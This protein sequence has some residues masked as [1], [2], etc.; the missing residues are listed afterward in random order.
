MKI[1][2]KK[3]PTHIAIIMDGNGRWAKKRNLPKIAGHGQGVKTV[4]KIIAAAKK[5][6]VRVL[7]LYAFSTE[8]WKRPKKE[9][10]GLMSLLENYLEKQALKLHKEGVRLS[11]IGD[12]EGLP[13][14]VSKK[15]KE[16]IELTKSNTSFTL[17]IALNYG[18]RMEIVE[19]TKSILKDI[20]R[21]ALSIENL[22]E[23][24]FSRYLYTNNIPDP[25]LLIRTS[26]EMRV[27]N[28]LLWQIAYTEFYI[29]EKF[30][31]D[32]TEKDFEKAIA[33]FQKRKRR[34]GGR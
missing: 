7:S 6:G 18:A 12:I 5:R 15:L 16:V 28:F 30:W 13:A 11:A 4:E 24:V 10:D 19:A 25:D 1:D 26:G 21:G 29:T 9:V 32:F 17:N 3:I 34:F 22:T 33:E 8:N 27:S 23:K 14:S 20:G 2:Q 31:P